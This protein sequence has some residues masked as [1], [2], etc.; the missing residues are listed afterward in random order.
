MKNLAQRE[1]SC[2]AKNSTEWYVWRWWFCFACYL[3]FTEIIFGAW[4]TAYLWQYANMPL[5][6]LTIF[7]TWRYL[8]LTINNTYVNYTPLLRT[9][10]SDHYRGARLLHWR[11]WLNNGF[12]LCGVVCGINHFTH[13]LTHPATY[14]PTLWRMLEADDADIASR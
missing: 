4:C 12:F 10:P 11:T 3:R 13:Q 5:M 7:C 9:H 1:N 2:C 6:L 14:I 8:P